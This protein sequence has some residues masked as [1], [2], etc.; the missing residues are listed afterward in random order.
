MK[1]DLEVW[2]KG[3]HSGKFISKETLNH[4]GII[5][6]VSGIDVYKDTAQA[7]KIAYEKLGI[8]IINRVPLENAPP[9]CSSD[10]IINIPDRPYSRQ[11][12]GVYDTVMRHTF[13]CSDVNAVWELDTDALEYEDLMTPVPHS[14]RKDDI[15]RR[16]AFLGETG[17][18][19]PMLYT[20][21]FMWGVEVLGWEIFMEAAFSEPARF[22]RQFFLPCVE[23]SKRIVR[24]MAEA[25]TCPFIFLHDDLASATGPVFPPQWYEDW[26]FPHYQEIFAPAKALGKKVFMVADGNMTSF[27]PRL[28][29]LGVDGIMYENPATVLDAVI[30]CFG[31]PGKFFIGGIETAKLTFSSP[32]EVKKMVYGLMKKVEDKPGFAMCSCGGLHDNIPLENLIAYFDARADVGITP[33]TWRTRGKQ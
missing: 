11:K 9:P 20:T 10:N 16:E 32:A 13:A 6:L 28:V 12:L 22:H 1:K 14:C 30:D 21:L 15:K 2:T 7:Y 31:T 33:E 27:L 24:E 18:Y 25:S 23:K 8:D 5:E 4:R 17:F 3:K 29:E 26:I 19:Y